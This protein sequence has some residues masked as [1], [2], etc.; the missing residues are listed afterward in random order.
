MQFVVANRHIKQ[1]SKSLQCIS[2]IGDDLYIEGR[3]E[4]IKFTTVN[5][6]KSAFVVFHFS[7]SFFH[8]Y[9]L[10]SEE[11]IQYKAKSKLCFQMFHS[12]SNIDKCAMKIDT[13]GKISFYLLC[14]N[15]IQKTYS[16]NYE[17]S[18]LQS[19]VY[20]KNSPYRVSVKPKQISECL[21]YFASNT[22]EISINLQRDRLLIKS[23][24][25]D[26]RGLKNLYTELILDR[27]DFDDYDFNGDGEEISFNFKDLKTIMAYVD[28]INNPCTFFIE[29]GGLPFHI[30][31]KYSSTYEVDFVLATLQDNSQQSD[32]RQQYQQQQPYQQQQQQQQQQQYQPQQY[33]NSDTVGSSPLSMNIRNTPQQYRNSN[34]V[35]SPSI[36]QSNQQQYSPNE[37]NMYDNDMDTGPMDHDL[38]P[39]VNTN[40]AGDS[41]TSQLQQQQQQQ[42]IQTHVQQYNNQ[43][44]PSSMGSTSS[45]LTSNSKK[46][47]ISYRGLNLEADDD[48]DDDENGFNQNENEEQNIQTSQNQ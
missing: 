12:L 8:S 15:G 47:V 24:T 44:P 11:G 37:N 13:D 27:N 39:S 30:N 5:N 33:R 1:F 2:R 4:Y 9:H 35:G 42:Q 25:D 7:N 6:S 16:I 23:S 32:D 3:K 40:Y 20:N 46:P 43:M 14:K 26:K 28:V 22:E 17:L 31:L 29:R 36:G 10:E 38:S 21:N 45:Y 19:A 48:D 34:T 18:Q 41:R